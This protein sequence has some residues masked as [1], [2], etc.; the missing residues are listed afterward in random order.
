MLLLSLPLPVSRMKHRHRRIT[1]KTQMHRLQKMRREW[2]TDE[3]KQSS[4][5]IKTLLL[6]LFTQ[7]CSGKCFLFQQQSVHFISRA[8]KIVQMKETNM[9]GVSPPE[10]SRNRFQPGL[11]FSAT[12]NVYYG[13]KVSYRCLSVPGI[14]VIIFNILLMTAKLD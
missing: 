9:P 5:N 4:K 7:T 6:L 11:F 8:I 14:A 2:N 10:V 12:G 13:N 1:Q 3:R